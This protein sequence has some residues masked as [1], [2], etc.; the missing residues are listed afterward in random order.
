MPAAKQATIHPGN[1]FLFKKV[2]P[3]LGARC[4][5]TASSRSV[6]LCSSLQHDFA[7]TDTK[8]YGT[9]THIPAIFLHRTKSELW[10]PHVGQAEL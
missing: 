6:V 4:N 10:R 2:D 1:L 3:T 9:G 7:A 8:L 5:E